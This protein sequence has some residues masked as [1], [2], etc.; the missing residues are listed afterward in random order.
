LYRIAYAWTHNA[1]L[2]DDLVQ[3]TMERALR[4]SRQLQDLRAMPAWLAAILT[5]CWRDHLRTQRPMEDIADYNFEADAD[6]AVEHE[7]LDRQT[8]VRRAVANLPDAQR[9]VLSLVDLGEH[10]YA[11]VAR[12]LHIP[13]GTVMSR[14]SRARAALAVVLAGTVH[15]SNTV[16]LRRIK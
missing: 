9:E 1:A 11:E 12:M 5:N 13:I 8:R 10:S 4:K 6:P 7:R 15:E 16:N 14:L 2:A 3:Q